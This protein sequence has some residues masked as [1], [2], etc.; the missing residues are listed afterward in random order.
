MNDVG[1]FIIAGVYNISNIDGLLWKFNDSLIFIFAVIV[2][3]IN[4]SRLLIPGSYVWKIMWENMFNTRR[5]TKSTALNCI[6]HYTFIHVS[7]GMFAIASRISPF[8]SIVFGLLKYIL[9]LRKLHKK[10]PGA[11]KSGDPCSHVRE[12]REILGIN[13]RMTHHRCYIFLTQECN[14]DKNS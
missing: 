5:Y 11:V 4:T 9:F 3:M 14:F 8:G 13:I 1:L 2:W 12:K 6:F 10:K 7:E